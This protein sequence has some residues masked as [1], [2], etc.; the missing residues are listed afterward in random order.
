M[1]GRQ[2]VMAALTGQDRPAA[3]DARAVESAAVLFLSIAIVIVAAPART[4][5]QI[6]LENVIHDSDGVPHERIVR[7]ADAQSH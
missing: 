3:S 1:P 2:F 5:R 7:C 6:V 4:L